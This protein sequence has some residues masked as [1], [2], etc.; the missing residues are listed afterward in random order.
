[1]EKDREDAKE[2]AMQGKEVTFEFFNFGTKTHF[3]GHHRE[4]DCRGWRD[5]RSVYQES[6]EV[7]LMVLNT[8]VSLY[9]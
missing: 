3:A 5:S 4:E 2:K 1:M 9:R 6:V 7:K 8:C